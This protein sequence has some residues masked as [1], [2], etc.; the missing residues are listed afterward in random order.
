MTTINDSNIWICP[1][2]PEN[3]NKTIVNQYNGENIWALNA[4][5]QKSF[6]EIK[7][8]DIC[9]FGR[10]RDGEGLIYMGIIKSKKILQEIEDEW[11]FKSP[12]GVF[13][14]Y[15]FT[16]SIYKINISPN[17]A[18]DLRGWNKRQSWQ[19]QTKLGNECKEEF[20]NYLHSN[21]PEYFV[22]N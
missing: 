10:L 3:L 7:I 14:K 8:G 6:D 2:N 15:A 5:R 20:I 4:R 13:W 21:Y 19:S 12:S 16:L 22:T 11:P 1:A 18:R 9:L 17:K